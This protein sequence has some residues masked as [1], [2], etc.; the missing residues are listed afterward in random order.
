M[1]VNDMRLRD[2]ERVLGVHRTTVINWTKVATPV[3]NTPE[4]AEI[5]EVTQLDE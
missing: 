3:S 5:P 1:Y 2:I 4:A